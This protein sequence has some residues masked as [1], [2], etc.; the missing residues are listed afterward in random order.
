MAFVCNQYVVRLS[1]EKINNSHQ[2][3]QG[4]TIKLHASGHPK[5]SISCMQVKRH[6]IKSI[7]LKGFLLS[8]A[9]LPHFFLASLF[10]PQ[11]T[12]TRGLSIVPAH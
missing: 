7:P 3:F 9:L 11:S 5:L 2:R 12:P 10:P 1:V 4:F 6:T 8:S